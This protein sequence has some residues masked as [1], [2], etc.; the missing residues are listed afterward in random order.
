[1]SEFTLGGYM[2]KHDRAA[3]F[4]GSDGRAYSV[5]LY[6]DEEP[7]VATSLPLGAGRLTRDWFSADPPPR[8]EVKELRRWVRAQ[9]AIVVGPAEVCRLV[10]AVAGAGQ[11]LDDALEVI[12]HRRGLALELLAVRVRE[13]RSRLR[14]QLV[15]RDVLG[16][17]ASASS[18]SRSRSAVV[19]PGMP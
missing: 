5:A 1:M 8:R 18:R 17:S 19:W 9:I 3:A 2:K 16:A 10:P 11:S 7:D 4:G 15:R 14:L 12:L 6:I 13:A